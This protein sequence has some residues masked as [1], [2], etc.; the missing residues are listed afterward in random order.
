MTKLNL[1]NQ[2]NKPAPFPP[3]SNHLRQY[4]QAF[5]LF[6]LLAVI[7]IITIISF[8]SLP[9]LKGFSSS[10]NRQAAI[11][12]VI[13]YIDQAR[14]AAQQ[15]GVRTYLIFTNNCVTSASGNPILTRNIQARGMRIMRENNPDLNPSTGN[16]NNSPL[17]PITRWTYLPKNIEF[18]IND[19][20]ATNSPPIP[21]S[22]NDLLSTHSQS[23]VFQPVSING[24]SVTPTQSHY[25]N[26][27]EFNSSTPLPA[28]VFSP[29][30]TIDFA[31]YADLVIYI[32]ET[33]R[34]NPT[35]IDAIR[36]SRYT[37]RPTKETIKL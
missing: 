22:G 1:Y 32:G 14:L 12:M 24:Q 8:A 28:L 31:N 10:N 29:D 37:G 25:L 21:G 15:Y 23:P 20:C 16:P 3:S 19:G 18:K 30:G 35:I 11:N 36:I 13:G 5:T 9:A 33:N 6:E 4:Y 26:Q 34:P 7:G 17:I 27:R 2:I